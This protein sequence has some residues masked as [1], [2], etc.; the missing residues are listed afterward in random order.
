MDD[1][2]KEEALVRE[3]HSCVRRHCCPPVGLGSGRSDLVHEAQA[4]YHALF[5]E[6]G[7]PLAL[8]SLL[9]CGVAMTSDQGTEAGFVRMPSVKF[10][11]VLPYAM[12]TCFVADGD[13][14]DGERD[15]SPD[16]TDLDLDL[17]HMLGIAGAFHVT[18][19][20]VKSLLY[21]LPAY[22]TWIHPHLT[23]M[24]ECM[25]ARFV[26]D[27]FKATCL[28]GGP[29]QC[30]SDLF[31]SFGATLIK[32]R[33]SCVAK[34]VKRL[35]ERESPLRRFW[36]LQKMQYRDAA[37]PGAEA[38]D[39]DGG[40]QAPVA[41]EGAPIGGERMHLPSLQKATIA[42]ASTGVWF[43]LHMFSLLTDTI[44]DIDAWFASCPCH[45]C[46]S[47]QERLAGYA[48]TG[49][50][51]GA[52]SCPLAGRR[53]AGVA[54]GELEAWIADLLQ[55]RMA[56]V[57]GLPNAEQCTAEDRGKVLEDFEIARQHI[58]AA[59]R[60]H[61]ANFYQTPFVFCGIASA[62]EEKGRACYRKGLRL[63]RRMSPEQLAGAHR[64]TRE[65]CTEGSETFAQFRQWCMGSPA[66]ELPLVARLRVV[67]L[68]IPSIESTIEGR[69]ATVHRSIRSA[70]HSGPVHVSLGERFPLLMEQVRKDPGVLKELVHDCER[71]YHP[72]R[73]AASLGLSAHPSLHGMY[74][75]IV[76]QDPERGMELTLSS[77]WKHVSKVKGVVYHT[78]LRMQFSE[79]SHLGKRFEGTKSMSLPA[80]AAADV[81][82]RAELEAFRALHRPGTYY[83][84][85]HGHGGEGN[86]ETDPFKPFADVLFRNAAAD[87]AQDG[88]DV[89]G[90]FDFAADGDGSAAV[91]VAADAPNVP[92]YFF[93]VISTRLAS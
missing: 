71:M 73:G 47:G 38:N 4:L 28:L 45:D 16:A 93:R 39:G 84:V 1:L 60:G 80:G 81:R 43:Y 56:S 79:L 59:I 24:V 87:A 2:A 75:D 3:I 31:N 12:P 32:W 6:C 85:P 92:H 50:S 36:D 15:G 10:S 49:V 13:C 14:S 18:S 5:L 17:K 25:N 62:D 20:I 34:V 42:F 66:E 19:N 44:D 29:G 8:Q 48:R 63:A 46:P 35:L 70:P 40:H 55:M 23:A 72:A 7:S 77:T 69:H 90:D 54:T 64:L 9:R 57:L 37:Q 68:L 67:L 11:E 52:F 51:F 27:R 33:F 53:V 22:S 78:D 61:F 41:P 86:C 30:F 21:A 58:M 76:V 88:G 26:R 74:E 89:S 82:Q 83:S 91:D 65:M